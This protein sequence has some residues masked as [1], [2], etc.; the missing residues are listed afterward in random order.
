MTQPLNPSVPTRTHIDPGDPDPVRTETPGE[1]EAAVIDPPQPAEELDLP[2]PTAEEDAAPLDIRSSWA[3]ART[4]TPPS[5]TGGRSRR[6][7]WSC[8]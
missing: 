2:E 8:T 4:A 1:P 3:M 6:V 7:P 5:A